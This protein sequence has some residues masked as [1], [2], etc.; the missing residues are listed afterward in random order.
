ME[1]SDVV[2]L[3]LYLLCGGLAFAG[4]VTDLQRQYPCLAQEDYWS[5]RIM[6]LPYRRAVVE[7][8][9]VD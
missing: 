6:S 3:C 9:S 1:T 2:L 5:D 4:S 7:A 8:A